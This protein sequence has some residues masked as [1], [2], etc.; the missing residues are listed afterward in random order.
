M[1]I[2]SVSFQIDQ[3]PEGVEKGKRKLEGGEMS[4]YPQPG[5]G[6]LASTA[7]KLGHGCGPYSM[8]PCCE[9]RYGQK[10]AALSLEAETSG[11]LLM[12]SLHGSNFAAMLLVKMGV[13]ASEILLTGHRCSERR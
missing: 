8:H 6:G 4:F 12:C 10:I 5:L 9:R 2:F 11:A 3:M 13:C 7:Q 1:L